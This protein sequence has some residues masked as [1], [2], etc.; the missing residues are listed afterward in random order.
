MTINTL[1]IAMEIHDYLLMDETSQIIYIFY[2]LF[3][4]NVRQK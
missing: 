3:Y 4:T 1:L 2:K